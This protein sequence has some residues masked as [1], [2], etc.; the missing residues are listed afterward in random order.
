VFYLQAEFLIQIFIQNFSVRYIP[1][2][3]SSKNKQQLA[4]LQYEQTAVGNPPVRT[5]SSWQPSSKNKQQL[6]T[7][8]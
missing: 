4:T 8:Q 5:S 3:A 7:L 1:T 6:A 2:V